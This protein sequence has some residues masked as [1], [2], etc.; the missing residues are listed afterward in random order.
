MP[1][2][3]PTLAGIAVGA[4]VV[5]LLVVAVGRV[6]PFALEQRQVVSSV[7][8]PPPLFTISPVRIPP[9]RSACTNDVALDR[10]SGVAAVR[11]APSATGPVRL[12]LS[13]RAGDWRAVAQFRSGLGVHGDV[14]EAAFP[15]PP[16][17]RTATLCVRNAG[18]GPVALVGTEEPRTATPSV[19]TIEGVTQ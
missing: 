19:T 13:A 3:R 9:G 12:A 7:P 2:V 17:P 16:A 8:V 10:D 5:V 18:S 4:A 1:R 6:A 11:A 14:L 15:P